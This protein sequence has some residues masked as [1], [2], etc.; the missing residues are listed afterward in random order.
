VVQV[1]R[2]HPVAAVAG[3]YLVLAL[4]LFS[5]GLMPGRTLSASDYLWT[6]TPWNASPPAGVPLFGSNREEFDSTVQFQPALQAVRAALPDV[7]LWDS[8]TLSGRPL[9]GDPQAAVFSIFSIPAY[10]LP[11]WKSLAIM[12]ALKVFVGAFGAFLLGRMLGMRLGGA[13]VCG[14]AFGFSL[15]QVTWVSWPHSGVWAFLPWLCLLCEACVRRPGPLPFAGLAGVVGLQFLAGHPSSSYQVLFVAALFW[16]GRILVARQSWRWVGLRLLT[17]AGALVVGAALAALMLVPF[18]ELLSHSNDAD[19]RSSVSQFFKAPPRFVFGLLLHDYW[20]HGRGAVTF[21]SQLPE[22]AYYVGALPLM[23]ALAALIARPARERIAVAGF[24]VAAMLVA[25]GTAPLYDLVLKLPGFSAAHN[26]RFAVVTVLCLAVLAGWG[27][28]DLSGDGLS[29]ARRAWVAGLAALL[30][31]LPIVALAAGGHLARDAIGPAL[32]VAWGFETPTP[33]LAKSVAGGFAG[34]V[35]LASLFEWLVLAGIALVLVLLRLRGNLGGTLFAGLA[36]ALVAVDLFVAGMGYNTAIPVSHA[37]QPATP[38]IRFLQATR[39]ARFTA[40]KPEARVSFSAPLPPNVAM[41]YG[42]Y[43][44]RGYVI[45]TEER[46]QRIWRRS[47]VANPRCY[48]IFCT[49][50]AAATSRSM[51]ALALF[52]V[53]YLLQNFGDPPLRLPGTRLAYNGPDARIYTNPQ[54]LPR[55]FLVGGQHVVASGGAALDA[56]TA[57]TFS[58]RAVAVTEKP[59]AGLPRGAAGRAPGSARIADYEAERVSV[60][61]VSGR[62]ALLVLTDNWYPGWRASVDGRDVPIHRVDYVVRGV[63]VPA[64][65]HT[66]EFRYRPASWR[67]GWILSLCALLVIAAA[68]ALGVRRARALS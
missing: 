51:R 45:P 12:A 49:T 41:R 42:L 63:V 30:A 68:T 33:E 15:W 62:P 38:A 32:R 9:L 23:L 2:R 57:A 50:V 8:A 3:L 44:T 36:T 18:G 14:L 60:H 35:E 7:P 29:R 11:F 24:G 26:G 61:T 58:A 13:L 19:L 28:D 64:G 21:A 48:Y 22:R 1:I 34:V 6:A 40:L 10:I 53:K 20:G 67:V 4:I 46:Y 17:L 5:P 31:G 37:V 52:G 56:V 16:A 66:V 47:I 55:A 27:L 25:T 59:I 65:A 54:A 43:D 39:P